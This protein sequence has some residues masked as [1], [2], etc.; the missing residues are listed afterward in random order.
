MF[1]FLNFWPQYM[2]RG[3]LIPHPGIEPCHLQWK[4]GVPTSGLPRSSLKPFHFRADKTEAQKSEVSPWGKQK[5][6][7]FSAFSC[8]TAE[9][10]PALPGLWVRAGFQSSGVS[11]GRGAGTQEVGESLA[12]PGVL[13]VLSPLLG[14]ATHSISSPTSGSGSRARVGRWGQV[15]PSSPLLLP[16]LCHFL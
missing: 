11:K 15:L 4:G 10:S 7:L 16:L 5:T 12:P 6:L 1:C 8:G 14:T 2:A 9:L 13:L 3:F